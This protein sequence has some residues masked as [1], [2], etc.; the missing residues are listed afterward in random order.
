MYEEFKV[1]YIDAQKVY[2]DYAN[3]HQN[4]INKKYQV[5]LDRLHNEMDLAFSIYSQMA[6]TLEMARAKVQEDTPVCVIIEPAYIQIK[7]SSPRK[8]MMAALYVFLA[9]FGTSAWII[10]KDR[11]IKN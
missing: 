4:V 10:I 7:A 2:A 8:V 5:E 11:I 9:F 3:L 1:K 6:Q